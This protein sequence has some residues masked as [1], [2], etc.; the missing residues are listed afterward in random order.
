MGVLLRITQIISGL[1]FRL[2]FKPW[3]IKDI[4]FAA[5]M[6]GFLL[7]RTKNALTEC[8]CTPVDDI[9]K[10]KYKNCSDIHDRSNL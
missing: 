2:R 3:S 4:V 8:K 9:L 5:S 7:E 10:D 1:W 6:V